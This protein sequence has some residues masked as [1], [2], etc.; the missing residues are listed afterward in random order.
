M[1]CYQIPDE[2]CGDLQRWHGRSI[3]GDHQ[4][5]VALQAQLGH[6]AANLVGEHAMGGVDDREPQDRADDFGA[7][8]AAL[9]RKLK[10]PSRGEEDD[11]ADAA[12]IFLLSV[13]KGV[14]SPEEVDSALKSVGDILEIPEGD[15]EAEVK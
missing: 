12:E 14:V 9:R 3:R 8:G 11:D 10:S 5:G 13:G 1:K 6:S 2:A 7:L 15:I 4:V